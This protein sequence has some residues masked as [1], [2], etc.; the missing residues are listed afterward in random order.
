MKLCVSFSLKA[1]KGS[2]YCI[3]RLIVETGK[4]L[5]AFQVIK[6]QTVHILSTSVLCLIRNVWNA[7]WEENASYDKLLGSDN[8]LFYSSW[9]R[10]Y[11]LAAWP[12]ARHWPVDWPMFISSKHFLNMQK[13]FAMANWVCSFARNEMMI[14]DKT[15]STTNRKSYHIYFSSSSYYVREI[16][17][18]CCNAV[19]ANSNFVVGSVLRLRRNTHWQ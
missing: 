6:K 12:T 3:T 1:V 8:W 13:F 15:A 11:R 2:C 10:L 14:V 9:N 7:H 16:R 17:P 18:Q 4:Y 19:H 5:L